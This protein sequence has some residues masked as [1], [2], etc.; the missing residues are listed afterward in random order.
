MRRNYIV[1]KKI[2]IA[3]A[4]KGEQFPPNFNALDDG[5]VGRNI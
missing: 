2:S 3:V 4:L 1:N 5:P